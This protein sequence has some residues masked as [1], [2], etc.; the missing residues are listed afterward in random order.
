M[1]RHW[2]NDEDK[3]RNG[4]KDEMGICDVT[5]TKA[6]EGAQDLRFR[7]SV[8]FHIPVKFSFENFSFEKVRKQKAKCSITCNLNFIKVH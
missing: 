6:L 3:K 4:H 7:K 5:F 1:M 8:L 2:V